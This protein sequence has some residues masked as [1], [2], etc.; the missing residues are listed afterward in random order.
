[1]SQ[2]PGQRTAQGIWRSALRTLFLATLTI[3][4]GWNLY[5]LA[6]LQVPPSLFQSLSGLPCP[7]TGCTRSVFALGRGEVLESLRFNALAIPICLL[8]V[9]SATQLAWQLAARQRMV[10]GRPLAVLWGVI[11]P[12]A[13]IVKLLGDPAYW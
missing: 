10:L 5:W 13:W 7:T 4:V 3:Y 6:R 2:P 9:V 11:L 1:V 8:L 12:L